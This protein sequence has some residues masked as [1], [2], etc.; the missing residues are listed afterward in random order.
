M[1]ENGFAPTYYGDLEIPLFDD[2]NIYLSK[3]VAELIYL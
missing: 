3:Y 2:L 1:E